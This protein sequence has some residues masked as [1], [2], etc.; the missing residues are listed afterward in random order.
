[1]T[2]DYYRIFYYVAKYK[3]FSKAARMLDN[4]HLWHAGAFGIPVWD[5]GGFYSDCHNYDWQ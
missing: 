3:S 2:L 5:G 1:M 4:N